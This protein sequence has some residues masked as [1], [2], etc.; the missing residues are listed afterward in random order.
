MTSVLGAAFVVLLL[1]Y[2]AGIR[3]RG[4]PDKK[5]Q[6]RSYHSDI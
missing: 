5:R 4:N 6:Y 1:I 2:S 3:D